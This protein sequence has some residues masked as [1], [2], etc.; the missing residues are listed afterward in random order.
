MHQQQVN[1]YEELSSLKGITYASLNI[2]SLYRK[3]DEIKLL[4][5]QSKLDVLFLNESWLNQSI[6]DLEL[7]IPGYTLHRFDRDAGAGKRGGG[8]LVAYTRNHY[9]FDEISGWNL[10]C[11][12][13]EIQWIK[14]SLPNTRP[15]FLANI[16]RPPDGNLEAATN[17][18]ENKLLDIYNDSP[19]DI[20]LMGDLN[21]DLLD[22]RSPS[23]RKMK[24]FLRNSKLSQLVTC[25][26]RI[27]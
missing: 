26:T 20:V 24:D 19:G 13:L 12:D 2:C 6:G 17:I 10:C 9:H 7:L 23:S 5:H 11:P 14:L 18:I 27:G 21:V 15:T 16:Y 8:G 4:L 3:L 25:P 22:L 1:I